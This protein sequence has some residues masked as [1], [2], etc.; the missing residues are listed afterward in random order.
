M[1]ESSFGTFLKERR[2]AR[3]LSIT[4]LSEQTG[5]GV[6]SLRSWERGE[7]VPS[8]SATYET[9]SKPLEVTV[10]ELRAAA[11]LLPPSEKKDDTAAEEPGVAP[12]PP[13]EPTPRV[14]MP[15]V[16]TYRDDPREMLSYWIRGLLTAAGLILLFIV[17]VWAVGGMLDQ[18]GG[19]FGE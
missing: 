7:T 14:G 2:L 11:G 5:Y 3:R 6:D 8:D 16:R 12:V 17:L 4:A 18:V 15:D 10:E 1:T 9:L 13:P 19:L